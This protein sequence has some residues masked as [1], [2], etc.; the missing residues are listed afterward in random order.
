MKEKKFL[1]LCQVHE[2]HWNLKGKCFPKKVLKENRE[3]SLEHLYCFQEDLIYKNKDY[4]FLAFTSNKKFTKTQ[5]KFLQKIIK[6]VS[7]SI[8]FMD[9]KKKLETSK[10]K[11][12]L[13]FD[14]FYQAL[15]ITDSNFQMVRTN[16]A[17]RKLTKQKKEH[18]SG[19]DIFS[20]FP[21]PVLPPK[22]K[23]SSWS[24]YGQY[25]DRPLSLEFSIKNIFLKNE[26]LKFKLILVKDVTEERKMEQQILSQTQ[27]KELGFI[28]SSLA[29]ELN[30]PI[31]G[32]KALLY[33]LE[34][35]SKEDQPSKHLLSEMNEAIRRCERIVTELLSASRKETED[36]KE[37]PSV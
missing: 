21:I 27:T 4:G 36:I 35:S 31:A 3:D 10:D 12:D 7:A 28:K 16:E 32:I 17:F 8:H 26:R 1:E 13:V 34:S 25:K 29:H 14:S 22:D 30:N 11:W 9:M 19:K 20:V 23:E 33:F 5:E 37:P 18:I 2:V 24:S 6:D 15:C